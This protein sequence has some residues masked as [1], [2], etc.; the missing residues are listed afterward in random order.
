MYAKPR[1]KPFKP[2][3]RYTTVLFPIEDVLDSDG[4][5]HPLSLQAT[6]AW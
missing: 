3:L 2:V 4:V 1:P 5:V 6:T